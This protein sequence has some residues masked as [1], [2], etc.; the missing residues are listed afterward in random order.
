MAFQTVVGLSTLFEV[1]RRKLQFGAIKPF[2]WQHQNGIYHKYM[3]IF[4]Q[5]LAYSVRIA[6][7]EDPKQ[8]PP[9]RLTE[10]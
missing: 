10:L 3:G 8:R 9:F 7:M 5:F 4:Q 1:N 6:R 2:H